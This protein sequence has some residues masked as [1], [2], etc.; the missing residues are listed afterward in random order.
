M[1]DASPIVYPTPMQI[2]AYGAAA[3]AGAGY[4]GPRG[5][6]SGIDIPPPPA[7]MSPDGGNMAWMTAPRSPPASGFVDRWRQRLAVFI[8]GADSGRALFPPMQPLQPIAQPWDFAAVGRPWDYPVGWNT[9]VTPRMGQKIGFPLLFELSNFDLVR[10]MISHVK[11]QCCNQQ[12]SVGPLDKKAARDSRMDQ[13]EDLFAYPDKVHTWNDWLKQ[14]LDQVLVYDAPAVW[15]RPTRGG[16]PY[17]LEIMDGSRFTPKIMA[18]GRLPPPE[19]GPAYQ[20]VLHGLPAVDYILPVPKGQPVPND[21]TGQ[22]YPQII[23]K[24]RFPR[25]DVPYGYGPIEQLLT[26]ILIGQRREEFFLDFYKNGSTPDLI[27]QTPELWNTEQ[28]QQFWNLWNSMLAG[29][30]EGRRGTMMVPNGVKAIDTKEGALTDNTD[31]WI[32]RLICFAFGLSPMPFTKM[33][34]RASGQQHAQQQK[35]EGV[36]PYLGW[37]A[38]F[39]NHYIR[40]AYG[41]RDVVFRWEEETESDP[42]QE[43]QRFQIYVNGKVYHPDEVRQKLGDEP[44]PDDLRAQMDQPTFAAS[45][46]ATVLP[47]E[48]QAD[49]D[50]RAAV[51]A[52]AAPAKPT[53][54][55]AAGGAAPGVAATKMG[56]GRLARS[57][58]RLI[59]GEYHY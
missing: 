30:L 2:A 49:A 1:A 16:D 10:I 14:L 40:L 19:Y 41:W 4:R 47:P 25:V 52:A 17:S 39:F 33:M 36:I 51:R 13:L 8:A 31:E 59:R 37:I 24:P 5:Y 57:A 45:P 50:A 22:P 27:L 18:D 54:P 44:M 9:R 32:I 7:N 34:N 43:A 20:Q 23:Y 38:E 12:W 48:Q 29:N 6:G 46:N 53:A 3:R 56:N 58:N 55:G 15:L 26:T 11:E 35:D 42:L 28:I 21:P